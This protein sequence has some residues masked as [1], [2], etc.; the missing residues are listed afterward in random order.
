MDKASIMEIRS[1]KNPPIAV[2]LVMETL[3]IV[4]DLTPDWYSSKKL[5][6]DFEFLKKIFEFEP[7]SVDEKKLEKLRPY[8][9]HKELKPERIIQVSK[10]CS[11]LFAWVRALENYARQ[12]RNIP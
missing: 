2:K 4:F 1:F 6:N 12:L 10:A 8:I 9:N 11:A 7:Y 3:C 5:L